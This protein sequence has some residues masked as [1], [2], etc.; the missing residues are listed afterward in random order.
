M[1]YSVNGVSFTEAQI[2]LLH[3]LKNMLGDSK[4]DSNHFVCDKCES[5]HM[6]VMQELAVWFLEHELE[7]D[8]LEEERECWLESSIQKMEQSVE[9]HAV[10]SSRDLFCLW[11]AFDYLDFQL[12]A[13]PLQV[14]LTRHLPADSTEL[15]HLF[16][17]EGEEPQLDESTMNHIIQLA[18]VLPQTD[19]LQRAKACLTKYVSLQQEHQPSQRKK[20][21]T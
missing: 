17:Q 20:Q 11:V 2:S 18:T 1:E 16:R 13:K 21:K 12:L 15:L 19:S 8:A 14:Y 6:C 3:T 7:P 9:R 5:K 10:S 4:R